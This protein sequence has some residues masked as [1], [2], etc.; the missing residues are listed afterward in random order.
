MMMVPE[1]MFCEIVLAGMPAAAARVIP[2]DWRVFRY[3]T[4][5]EADPSPVDESIGRAEYSESP[6]PPPGA[7]P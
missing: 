7:A 3:V 1:R 2:I 6:P 5:P 4:S